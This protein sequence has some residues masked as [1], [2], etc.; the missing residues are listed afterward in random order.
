MP[1]EHQSGFGEGCGGGGPLYFILNGNTIY[2]Y[3]N[4]SPSRHANFS[5]TVMNNRWRMAESMAG[6]Q[7]TVMEVMLSSACRGGDMHR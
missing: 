6:P 4:V 5:Q 3:G 1:T 7:H 2:A